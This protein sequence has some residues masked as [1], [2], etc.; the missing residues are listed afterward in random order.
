MQQVSIKGLYKVAKDMN[1]LVEHILRY[2]AVSDNAKLVYL[3]PLF[4]H[5][6]YLA[7][8]QSAWLYREGKSALRVKQ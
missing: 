8:S 3:S 5:C 7:F 1:W 2:A 4:G 6:L